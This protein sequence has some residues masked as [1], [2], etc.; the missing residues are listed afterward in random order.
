M[1][2]PVAVDPKYKG[3][4]GWLLLLCIILTVL[5]P[6]MTFFV[7]FADFK[8]FNAMSLLGVADTFWIV[9]ITLFGMYAGINLWTVRSN[10]V[11]ITKIYLLAMAGYAL[12]ITGYAFFI[13]MP[14]DPTAYDITTAVGAMV[15]LLAFAVIW[16]HYLLRSKRVKATY[17]AGQDIDL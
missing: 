16:Y 11:K 10:A 1:S 6:L 17:P 3:V 8:G 13:L 2:E 14:Q 5:N 12:F 9:L 15:R 4:K 7:Y